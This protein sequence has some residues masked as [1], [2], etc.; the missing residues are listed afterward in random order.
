MRAP[1]SKDLIASPWAFCGLGFGSGLA[2]VVPGTFGT[3]TA[4][5]LYWLLASLPEAIYLI[6]LLGIITL[7]IPICGRTA[8]QLQAHDHPAI[9][10]DEIAGYLLTMVFMPFTMANVVAGFLLFRLFDI[11]KPWPIRAID[12]NVHGGIGI[13]MDDLLAAVFAWCCLA[14][15]NYYNP[16]GLFP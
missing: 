7:G 3:L 13:M 9:V 5:P 1:D 8:D 11:V 4:I 12:H 2:P 15:L 14:L 16:F 6:V 10:W